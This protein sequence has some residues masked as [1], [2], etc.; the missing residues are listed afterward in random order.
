MNLEQFLDLKSNISP[1][2]AQS[3]NNDLAKRSAI[4]IP[5]SHRTKVLDYLIDA[6]NMNSVRHE[7]SP[8]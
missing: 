4:E 8:N 7:I 3:L 6:L 1:E 5:V 2:D